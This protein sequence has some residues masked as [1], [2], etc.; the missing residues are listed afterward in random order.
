MRATGKSI[1]LDGLGGPG[2]VDFCPMHYSAIQLDKSVNNRN[3]Y[4]A[5]LTFSEDL[6]PAGQWRLI[7]NWTL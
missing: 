1:W 7:K 3:S 5:E 6:L 4:T 2:T